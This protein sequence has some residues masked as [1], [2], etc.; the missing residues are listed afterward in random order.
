MDLEMILIS[1][2]FLIGFI[3]LGY[4]LLTMPS[5]RRK[6]MILDWLLQAVIY[7]EKE[8]GSKTGALK[9][10]K[11]YDMYLKQFPFISKFV[12]REVFIELVGLALKEMN[13]MLSSNAKVIE[14]VKGKD[15]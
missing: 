15:V 12:P 4:Q 2:A 7:A 13:R 6:Q 8:F 9:F 5:E 14:Y 11:V 10:S 3:L 1:V